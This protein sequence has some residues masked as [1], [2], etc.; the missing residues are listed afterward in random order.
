[1]LLFVYLLTLFAVVALYYKKKKKKLNALSQFFGKKEPYFFLVF[2]WLQTPSSLLKF[3]R[4]SVK[5]ICSYLF[6]NTY[7]FTLKVPV[8]F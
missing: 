2:I 5:Q 7:L 8:S 3:A 4:Q 6:L 1:M